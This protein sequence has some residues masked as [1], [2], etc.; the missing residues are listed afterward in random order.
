VNA[1]VNFGIGSWSAHMSVSV[2]RNDELDD[3]ELADIGSVESLVERADSDERAQLG[4][5]R[6]VPRPRPPSS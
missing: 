5:R 2:G 3:D 6:D 1:F 4:F